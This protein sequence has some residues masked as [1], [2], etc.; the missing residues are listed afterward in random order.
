MP[1][2]QDG[3]NERGVRLAVPAHAAPFWKYL[4]RFARFVQNEFT[5]PIGG[6]SVNLII[7]TH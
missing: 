5:A 6:A 3:I 7:A 1:L 2:V 4:D